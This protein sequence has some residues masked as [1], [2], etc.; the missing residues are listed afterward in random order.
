MKLIALTMK[1]T[2]LTMKLTALT[3]KTIALVIKLTLVTTNPSCIHD[4]TKRGD[5]FAE[6]RT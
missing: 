1:L 5:F 2:A 6:R 3:I 4:E